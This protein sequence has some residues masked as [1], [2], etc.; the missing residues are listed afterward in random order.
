MSDSK[1]PAQLYAVAEQCYPDDREARRHLYHGLM[2]QHGH[3][4]EGEPEPL[5]CGWSPGDRQEEE[6]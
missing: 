1:S 4:V 5:P 6:Q 2:V 3:L